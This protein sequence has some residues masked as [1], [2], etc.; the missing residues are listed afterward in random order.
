MAKMFYNVEEA[1]ERL[2][3]T[4]EELR[5]LVR[6]GTLREFRDAGN[7]NYKVE[8][9]EK[10]AGPSGGGGSGG[11]SSASASASGEIVLEPADDSGIELA[12]GGSDVLSLEEVDASEDTAAGG[13]TAG[14]GKK[15]SKED[16]VVPSVGVNVFDDDELDESVDPLAQTA[17]T[18]VGGLGI[19]GGGSG[20]GSG[21]MNLTRESDDT[22]LGSELLEEIYSDD[23]EGEP[24][25]EMGEAT[26]AGLEEA[27]SDTPEPQPATA[28]DDAFDAA[29]PEVE[30]A[31]APQRR[32]RTETVVEYGAD[33]VSAG[34]TAM[35]V[36]AVIVMAVA[37]LAG[38]AMVRGV[39]PGLL[40]T[41]YN[42]LGMFAGASL[43]LAL[44]AAGVTFL[45]A[46]RSK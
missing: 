17:V 2:G 45:L 18:D 46:R 22:S 42:K 26:R 33:A 32:V 36:V 5:E 21:I 19:D 37:G 44:L 28:A 7:V 3:K 15:K 10:L 34:L 30:A 29:E 31:A 39:T 11:S 12:S 14:G 43:V 35:M 24:Q 38:A 41:I 27:I 40:T 16:S 6:E 13:S 20:S 23:E 8:D 25:V 9:V 4:P 1:A